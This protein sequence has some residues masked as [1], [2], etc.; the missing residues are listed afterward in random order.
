M[1]PSARGPGTLH[2]L[3]SS[4][5]TEGLQSNGAAGG[6][7]LLS[8][9]DRPVIGLWGGDVNTEPLIISLD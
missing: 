8:L 4:V 7:R 3:Q 6:F 9:I 1:P 2:L 5:D